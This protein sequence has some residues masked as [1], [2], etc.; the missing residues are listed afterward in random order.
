MVPVWISFVAETLSGERTTGARLAMR[1][2]EKLFLLVFVLLQRI[3]VSLL[4]RCSRD[5][6]ENWPLHAS[7]QSVLF[8]IR[9]SL[10]LGRLR[11]SVL[12]VTSCGKMGVMF[13]LRRRLELS[14]FGISNVYAS[15]N[16][17]VTS[18]V[19]LGRNEA[20]ALPMGQMI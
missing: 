18:S 1:F 12:C 7:T 17:D 15:S 8:S 10:C 3:F 19:K 4:Q 5:S 6:Q 2:M 11:R 13:F 14:V 16:E 9:G 20:D